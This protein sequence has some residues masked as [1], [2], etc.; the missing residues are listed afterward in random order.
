MTKT[1]FIQLAS[2]SAV[3]A[4]TALATAQ[5]QQT[6]YYD[7][8]G[9]RRG[10]TSQ[11]RNSQT[12]SS[13]NSSG[14]YTGRM[15]ISGHPKNPTSN[16]YYDNSGR[17]QGYSRS[18]SGNT[19]RYYD[20]SGRYSG[21]ARTSGNT[22]TVY[23]NS[24][25]ILQRQQTSSD[26]RTRYYDASGRYQGTSSNSNPMSNNYATKQLLDCKMKKDKK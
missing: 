11:A 22:T 3:I 10:Y 26:G 9:R 8:T 13:Y 2:A 18:S 1:R 24:G 7:N 21:Y 16:S 14:V 19:T 17:Y 12:L 20:G 5:S 25:R 6:T 4:A 15:T 23:D